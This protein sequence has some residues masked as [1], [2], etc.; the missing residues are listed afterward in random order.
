MYLITNLRAAWSMCSASLPNLSICQK[1]Q[2]LKGEVYHYIR[3]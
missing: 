2:T 3:F 1:P